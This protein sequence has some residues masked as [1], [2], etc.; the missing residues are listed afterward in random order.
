[1][2]ELRETPGR[3]SVMIE[4]MRDHLIEFKEVG[5]DREAAMVYLRRQLEKAVERGKLAAIVLRLLEEG[6]SHDPR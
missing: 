4:V 1:M 5:A 3:H 2:I 6:E